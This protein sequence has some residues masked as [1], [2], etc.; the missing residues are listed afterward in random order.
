MT[1]KK[2]PL[3]TEPAKNTDPQA[4]VTK[5]TKATAT[6]VSTK[7]TV[8]KSQNKVSKLA[9][10]AIVIALGITAIHYFW[11]QQQNQLSLK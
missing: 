2:P 7:D 5:K 9:L 1:D 4:P 3:A 6:K 11:Q 10:V 8:A